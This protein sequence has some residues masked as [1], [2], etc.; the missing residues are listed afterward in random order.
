MSASSS[1]EYNEIANNILLNL[2]YEESH[3]DLIVSNV[4]N[5]KRQSFGYMTFSSVLKSRYLDTCTALAHTVLKLLEQFSQ[6][7]RLYI[8]SKRQKVKNRQD[9]QGEE[10]ESDDERTVTRK[11]AEKAF[12]FSAFESVR[13]YRA[14]FD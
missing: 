1:E 10:S 8:R 14:S 4:R 11:V 7:R 6:D 5:Y 2:F 12:Q 13:I 9:N 3:L